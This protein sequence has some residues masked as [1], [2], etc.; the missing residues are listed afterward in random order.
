MNK[1][2]KEL[3]EFI[4]EKTEYYN[5]EFC[6]NEYKH[7][8]AHKIVYDFLKVIVDNTG[9][10]DYIFVYA[11]TKLEEKHGKYM[12][13]YL[14]EILDNYC[15]YPDYFDEAVAFA[16][17]YNIGLHYYRYYQIKELFEFITKCPYLA[18]FR[19]KYPLSF[20]SIGR[21]CSMNGMF[22]RMLLFDHAI[23]RNLKKYKNENRDSFKTTKYGYVQTGDNVAVKIGIV[24]AT[25]SIFEQSFIRGILDKNIKSDDNNHFSID[26]IEN[27]TTEKLNALIEIHDNYKMDVSL[28][29]NES[30]DIA[31]DYV[32]Q[33]IDY[34][35][36]YPKYPF[37]KSQLLFYKAIYNKQIIDFTL[38]AEIKDLL[39]KAKSLENVKANDYDLRVSK[40]ELFLKRVENYM[41]RSYTQNKMDLEYYRI[42][43]EIIHMQTCPSP[44]KRIKPS[45]NGSDS[46]SFISYST[47][48]FKSVYCDL[49]AFKNRGISFWYD[50]EVVPGE[51]WHKV[52]EEKIKNAS[53]IICY[54]SAAF[55]RSQA[56][57][58]ELTLFKKYNKPIIWVDL[59]GK[60]Q[61]S[62]IIV[63]ILRNSDFDLANQ[64]S[65]NMLNI[66][67]ELVDDDVD[68]ISRD[69]DPQAEA[70]I[71]RI[72]K[73]IKQ[74]FSNIIKTLYSEYLTIKNNKADFIPNEDY[75][76]ND[77]K[78]G[79]F[80]VMDGISRKRE[81]YKNNQSIAYDV[82]K[83]FADNIYNHIK[84]ELVKCKDFKDAK[85]MLT[86][87][88]K[89]ANKA[90]DVMLE[91]RKS[92]FKGYEYPGAVGIVAFT[93]NNILCYGAVGDCMGI[94]V[95]GNN[96]IIFS[97]KQTTFAFDVLNHERERN[98][99]YDEYVNIKSSP[100]GYGVINGDKNAIE[101]FN[102]SYI[103]LDLGDVIY[104][105]SDGVSDLIE[106]KKVNDYI[107]LSLEEIIDESIIQDKLMNKSHLDDKTII[108]ICIG[109]E[110]G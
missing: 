86:D 36:T 105:V 39:A 33:A 19:E 67:T 44:Q 60:K 108:K 78:N 9:C 2:E 20:D 61:I 90:V 59:T 110:Q 101:Y 25:C 38:L 55:L 17:Y 79:I 5:D 107:D 54:L 81:E 103:N 42:K 102:I 70:H 84:E 58:K 22:D 71:D 8:D 37:L 10:N 34:N 50:A 62:K 56:I 32:M 109:V 53:C 16:A 66:I 65:S 80:V 49:L 35:S 92:E 13:P 83:T 94:L 85:L 52:I 64:I 96:K 57:Y 51:Q 74:K 100:Y 82:S 27:L 77:N 76:I 91:S 28:I 48:D 95:R 45:V 88:F 4:F 15:N 99:L 72:E 24:T 7:K 43:D 6:L 41:E 23:M 11:V 40:Y 93:L 63:D 3:V 98:L 1:F 87:A 104:L 29:N 73:V 68:M 69:L 47:L 106:Y 75:V 14:F 18:I 89:K 30:L 97:P 12:L 46:Y 21:Y 26:H 31:M